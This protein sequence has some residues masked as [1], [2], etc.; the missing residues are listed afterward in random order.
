MY[1]GRLRST[2]M[3]WVLIFLINVIDTYTGTFFTYADANKLT[4]TFSL[5]TNS[6]STG[7]V[8]SKTTPRSYKDFVIFYECCFE[9]VVTTVREHTMIFGNLKNN[10]VNILEHMGGY[11]FEHL[12]CR[13]TLVFRKLKFFVVVHLFEPKLIRFDRN[14][15]FS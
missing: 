7:I 10:L 9:R 1:R 15:D 11:T 6:A 5:C 8:H 2:L 3:S 14:F 13:Q 12:Q 4:E